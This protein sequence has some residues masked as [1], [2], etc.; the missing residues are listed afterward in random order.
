[1]SAAKASG[2][3]FGQPPLSAFDKL[4]KFVSLAAAGKLQTYPQQSEIYSSVPIGD[5]GQ[6]IDQSLEEALQVWLRIGGLKPASGTGAKAAGHGAI[7][8]SRGK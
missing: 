6:N 5:G 4:W 8:V 1:M 3:P 2:S 7:K